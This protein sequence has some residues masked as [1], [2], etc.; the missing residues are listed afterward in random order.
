[1]V[2]RWKHLACRPRE[3][4]PLAKERRKGDVGRGKGMEEGENE[5]PGKT[6]HDKQPRRPRRARRRL[7]IPILNGHTL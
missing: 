6:Q 7:I 3:V 5:N 1:M 2:S 4:R